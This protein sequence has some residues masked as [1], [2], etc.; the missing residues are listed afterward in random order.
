MQEGLAR[1]VLL[2]RVQGARDRL[3]VDALAGA[4]VARAIAEQAHAREQ[5]GVAA[6]ES[7]AA[8]PGRVAPRSSELT[9]WPR[10]R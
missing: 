6:S 8:A 3:Q 5:L 1:A 2:Q 9:S 7:G 10:R 4:G